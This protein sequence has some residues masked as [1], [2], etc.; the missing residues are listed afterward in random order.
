MRSRGPKVLIS[1][2]DCK[3]QRLVRSDY[4]KV[5]IGLCRSCNGKRANK[6]AKRVKTGRYSECLYCSGKFWLYKHLESTSKFCS[7]PCADLSKTVYKKE[8]RSCL[9][10]SNIFDYSN[11]P[12]SNNSGHFCSLKC[13]D[14]SYLKPDKFIRSGWKGPRNRFL[15]NGNNFCFKC[16]SSNNLQVHHL[17]PHYLTKDNN[18]SNLVTLCKNCHLIADKLTLKAW[19]KSKHIGLLVSAIIGAKLE[20]KWHLYKGRFL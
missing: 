13:R 15:K 5:S 9:Q 20:D 17:I 1:C 8:K 12:K 14:K 10:C 16:Y 18:D 2:P 4:A 6:L 3:Y 11:K 19:K 7:K